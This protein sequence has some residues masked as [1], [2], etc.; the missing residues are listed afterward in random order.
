MGVFEG[1]KRT[2]NIAGSN[3]TIVTK[4][5]IYSQFDLINGEVIIAAPQYER[6]GRLIKLELKEFWTERRSTGKST[7]TVTVYKTHA[8][9]TLER[10]F[11][12][13]PGTEHRFPFEVQLPMNC[14]VSIGKTGWC[15][16]VTMEIPKAIDPK[17]KIVLKIQPA[18]EFLSI[19]EVCEENMQFQEETRFRR[20]SQK[21]STTYFR[22]LPPEVLKS[23][24]DYLALELLQNEEGGVDGHLIFNLQEKTVFDYFKAM[25]GKDRIRK[26]IQLGASELFLPDGRTNDRDI[27]KVIAAELK[28]VIGERTR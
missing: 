18:E 5:D 3:I 27:A 9:L 23:E 28:A 20:W 14:R 7:T 11:H 6:A 19:V 4:D 16:A 1:L 10:E 12:F 22:L 25:L 2:L 26:R 13:R 15:L 8:E 21:S 24:L 17:G